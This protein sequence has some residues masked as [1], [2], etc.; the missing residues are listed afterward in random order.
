MD[1]IKRGGT[2]RGFPDHP[3]EGRGEKE[4]SRTRLRIHGQHLWGNYPSVQVTRFLP[5]SLL[6]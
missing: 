6:L 3:R 4:I 1:G 2:P 5:C